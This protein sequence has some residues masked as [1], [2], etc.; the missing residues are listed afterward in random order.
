MLQCYLGSC[1]SPVTP[2]GYN[3]Q[4][5]YQEATYWCSITYYE[6]DQCIREAF[7]ATQPC[8]VV[9]GYTDPCKNADHFCLGLSNVNRNLIHSQLGRGVQLV[10]VGGKVFAECLSDRAIFVQSQYCNNS[11]NFHP[12]TVCKVPPGCSLEIFSNLEFAQLLAQS[13]NQGFEAV[14]N[15]MKFCTIYLSF[16]KGWNSEYSVP[17][18]TISLNGPL[19]WLDRVL[20][21]IDH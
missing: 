1:L 15:L 12:T 20:S 11:N 8:V 5:K 2:D 3:L 13:I 14:F 16:V 18:V 10:Y 17:N 4:I 6:R 7:N 9:D 21:Q 19:L